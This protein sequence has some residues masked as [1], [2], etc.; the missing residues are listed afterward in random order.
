MWMF[1]EYF[2][3]S[4][5]IRIA[6][7]NQWDFVVSFHRFLSHIKIKSRGRKATM[8]NNT[9]MRKIPTEMQIF[10]LTK[11]K[12]FYKWK[13][14]YKNL[15]RHLEDFVYFICNQR[16]TQPGQRSGKWNCNRKTRHA[17]KSFKDFSTDT[18][19]RT[20]GRNP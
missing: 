13:K 1:D 9:N 10:V 17:V 16:N 11:C 12:Y 7:E 4:L 19:T 2:P 6:N 8:T 18:Q 5:P 3:V 14:V 15:P 20:F